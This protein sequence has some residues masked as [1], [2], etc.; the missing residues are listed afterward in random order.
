MLN[1]ERDDAFAEV[2]EKMHPQ[3]DRFFHRRLKNARTS[4]TADWALMKDDLVQQTACKALEYSRTPNGA[5]YPLK[6]LI[7]IKANNV[8]SEYI[9]QSKNKPFKQSSENTLEKESKDPDPYKTIVKKDTL[10]R[11]PEKDGTNDLK[12]II[13]MVSEGYHYTEI[14]QML[15]KSEGAIKM[16]VFRLK[17]WLNRKG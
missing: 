14:A 6:V 2:F 13:R 16:K 1:Y 7:R 8:W 3:L 10:S 17:R 11:L 5:N 12:I 9:R 15:N 4:G